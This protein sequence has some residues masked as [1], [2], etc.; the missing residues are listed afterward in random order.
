MH[1]LTNS[2][3]P[4]LSILVLVLF[5]PFVVSSCSKSDDEADLD[6]TLL[7]FVPDDS[8][9]LIANLEPLP[10]DILDKL[11]P[12]IDSMLRAYA[13]VFLAAVNAE[14]QTVDQEG[15]T[16][17]AEVANMQAIGEELV[18]LMTLEGLRSTGIGRESTM[19]F[20]GDGL[21]PVFRM[22][23]TDSAL[24]E[25]TIARIEEK[26]GSKMATASVGN[27]HY[28]YAGDDKGQLVL[29]LVGNDLVVTLVPANP[30][31]DLLKSV[32]G[33]NKPARSMAASGELKEMA[34]ANSFGPYYLL[35]VDVTRIAAT[36]LDEQSGSNAEI[37]AL[38]QYDATKL[39]DVCREEIREMA[40][41]VPRIIGGYTEI[42]TERVK[43]NFIVELRDDI[44]SGMKSL[45][46]PVQ[47]LGLTQGGLFSFG[48][49]LNVLA[50]REFYAS[51]LDAMEADP[52][53][54]ESFADL[55]NGVAQGRELLNQPVPPIAY[56]VKGFMAV[57]DALEGMNLAAQQPPTSID[58][59]FLISV[60]NPHGLV[61]MGAM[62][63]PDLAA[64]N[65]QADGKP[66]KINLPPVSP[67]ASEAF[68]AM[69]EDALAISIG[70]GGADRILELFDKEYADPAPFLSLFM[71]AGAYY[72]FV[73]ETM[74][75]K[76]T[77]DENSPPEI[78]EATSDL[79]RSMGDL[80]G[81]TSIDIQFTDRG[82]E[83]PSTVEFAE[84][85]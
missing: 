77:G 1:V 38:M 58:A 64:L 57:V 3:R 60:D 40:G 28:R 33:I 15:G 61:A 65:L 27:Q 19:V 12:G 75:Y 24:M 23:L 76:Q 62:F 10:D 68:I 81:D 41:V 43:S 46:A 82:V 52:F 32:L 48:M 16:D 70:A 20:Y 66:Q 31:D 13:K 63:S 5:L 51:R 71:D 85:K 79:M 56:S 53:E 29:A 34:E 47:G 78:A 37:L 4:Y 18:S 35:L 39:D 74:L 45:V 21:L 59:S 69:K 2:R 11:E 8:P 49:S 14:L 36:F 80:F 6:K 44:A 55:Q 30:A 42:T 9:Y 72:N 26:A 67:A 50:A 25:A 22:R 84:V 7:Q 54:C 73:A 83:V 17:D